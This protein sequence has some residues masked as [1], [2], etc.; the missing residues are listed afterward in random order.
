MSAWS[1]GRTTDG[2]KKSPD[3][4]K[5][6]WEALPGQYGRP[7]SVASFQKSQLGLNA[8][9]VCGVQVAPSEG[10]KAEYLTHK[11]FKIC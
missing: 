1:G 9:D 6:Q 11:L 4:P 5:N 2:G 7:P 8:H 3:F 10:R